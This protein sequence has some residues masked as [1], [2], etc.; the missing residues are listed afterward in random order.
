MRKLA[1]FLSWGII[2]ILL[3]ALAAFVVPFMGV[4]GGYHKVCADAAA[5]YGLDVNDYEIKFQKT[6]TTSTGE[7]VQGIY[8]IEDNKQTIIVQKSWS[9]PMMVATIFHEF[10]HA[11]QYAHELDMGDLSRE[12]HAEVLSFYQMWSS[13]KYKWDSFHL[14]PVHL[15]AKSE[16]YRAT[17]QIWHIMTSGATIDF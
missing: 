15:I 6:V 4:G 8:K 13:K 5:M 9:R 1:N 11:A 7:K 10:A 16:N 14:L 2:A 17:G 3:C 12:Q